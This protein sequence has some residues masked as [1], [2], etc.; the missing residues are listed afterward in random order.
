MKTDEMITDKK[1]LYEMNV[2]EE[3]LPAFSSRKNR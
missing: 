1:P 3:K 2:E